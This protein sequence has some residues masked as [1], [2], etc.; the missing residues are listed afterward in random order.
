MWNA[1]ET[2]ALTIR[3][4]KE[5]LMIFSFLIGNMTWTW[6]L[7]IVAACGMNKGS[8]KVLLN[9]TSLPKYVVCLV[10]FVST[11]LGISYLE[12][13]LLK[14]GGDLSAPNLERTQWIH[15]FTSFSLS[16]L[17]TLSDL[18]CK[19]NCFQAWMKAS[20]YSCSFIY[21]RCIFWSTAVC[22]W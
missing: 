17:D 10:V 7:M 22:T 20:T 4:K 2:S 19:P 14:G 18:D 9:W 15:R 1:C 8:I 21:A 5:L 13:K 12:E 11:I 3:N 16:E 6:N